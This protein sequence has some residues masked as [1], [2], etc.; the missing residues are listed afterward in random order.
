L[1][2]H[3]IFDFA[4]RGVHFAPAKSDQIGEARMRP[5]GDVVL[6]GQDDGLA[7]N[8]GI[9]RVKATRHVGRGDALHQRLVLA[10][11][12]RAERLAEIRIQVDLHAHSILRRILI[13]T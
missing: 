13:C 5:H 10:H 11:R 7:H 3:K 12:P 2:H 6:F 4:R 1:V 8:P 9:A